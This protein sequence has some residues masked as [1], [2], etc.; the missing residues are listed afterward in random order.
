MTAST[1]VAIGRV[2][3]S[4]VIAALLALGGCQ[5]LSVPGFG[6]SDAAPKEIPAATRAQFEAAL[7]AQRA[8][9]WGE[10]ESQY[11]QLLERNPHLSGPALN[12]ALIYAQ[13]QRPQQ[14]EE[15]FQRA[16]KINPDN[17]MAD[18]QYGVWLRAQ[19]RLKEAETM[20]LQAIARNADYA[21]AHLNLAIL[22]DIYLGRLPEALEHYQRYAALKGDEQG[23]VQGW[24]TDLQRRLQKAG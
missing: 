21:D 15:Y 3:T 5:S 4:L 14:A 16:L 17:A 18:D 11:A 13:T 22:Y 20:Y 24:I 6:G 8:G 9:N 1:F 7:A 12:L 23:P 19:G 10:A 2:R